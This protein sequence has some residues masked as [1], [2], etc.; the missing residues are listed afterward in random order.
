MNRLRA[1]SRAQSEVI[2]VV[3][4]L[5]ITVVGTTAIM[6]TG[7]SVFA[8]SQ[9]AADIGKAE[10]AMTQLDS[11]ASLVGHGESNSQRVS[12]S[13]YDSNRNT[14]MG[15]DADSK[16]YV[17][18]EEGKMTLTVETNDGNEHEMTVALGAVVHE[19]GDTAIAYQGGGVWKRSS[20]G[21]T[22]VSPPEFH[23][24]GDTLTMP[25]VLV[26][27]DGVVHDNVQIERGHLTGS[28]N[29][30]NEFDDLSQPLYGGNVTIVIESD[31]YEV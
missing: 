8:D 26:R 18:E 27:G 15:T 11:Q 21:S 29:E 14:R 25:L 31:Y 12:F 30:I 1:V 17:D 13:S 20:G 3:L 10:H 22:M 4:L 2:G 28:E 7:V 5:S 6:A 9:Q 24:R 19:Q 23:Y 16:T